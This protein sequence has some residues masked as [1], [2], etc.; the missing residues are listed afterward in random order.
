VQLRVAVLLAVA[1]LGVR[2]VAAELLGTRAGLGHVGGLV[3]SRDQ[4]Q[5]WGTAAG[6]DQLPGDAV[7]RPYKC[8]TGTCAYYTTLRAR[9]WAISKRRKRDAHLRREHSFLKYKLM[10]QASVP[11]LHTS[12]LSTE[13]SRCVV[14]FCSRIRGEMS[15]TRGPSLQAR[16]RRQLAHNPK[17]N[18]NTDDG[19]VAATEGTPLQF[20]SHLPM[21]PPMERSSGSSTNSLA[22]PPITYIYPY[23][24]KQTHQAH[25]RVRRHTIRSKPSQ[26]VTLQQANKV[27]RKSSTRVATTE[28]LCT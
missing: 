2:W 15:F 14:N 17:S 1:G 28:G 24:H 21:M 6:G 5:L 12:D 26:P 25:Q 9:V 11:H 10:Q 4:L 3:A 16:R 19:G 13:A 23:S 18:E 27:L 8:R 20:H 22:R 7:L